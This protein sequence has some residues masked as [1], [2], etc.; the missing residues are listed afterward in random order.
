MKARD[1][2]I[3]NEF[4]IYAQILLLS[5]AIYLLFICR[6]A[7]KVGIYRFPKLGMMCTRGSEHGKEGKIHPTS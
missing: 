3:A 7:I 1:A 6:W 5:L 2:Y 4:S